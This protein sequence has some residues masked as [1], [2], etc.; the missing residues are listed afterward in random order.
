MSRGFEMGGSPKRC[1]VR[2]S[3][4]RHVG[5][6]ASSLLACAEFILLDAR[7]QRGFPEDAAVPAVPG[8]GGCVAAEHP[9]GA[10]RRRSCGCE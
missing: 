2:A 5:W 7:F 8:S 6:H 1:L 9:Q 4:G 3:L 10:R